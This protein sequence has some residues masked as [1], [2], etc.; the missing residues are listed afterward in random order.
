MASEYAA[1]LL[2]VQDLLSRSEKI[3][4]GNITLDITVLPKSFINSLPK[5]LNEIAR[6]S[7]QNNTSSFS[8]FPRNSTSKSRR[9]TVTLEESQQVGARII[10]SRT[11]MR[12]SPTRIPIPRTKFP[13]FPSPQTKD[14]PIEINSTPRPASQI[15][16]TQPKEP[17]VSK[18]S[19]VYHF[20]NC[21]F[22]SGKNVNNDAKNDFDDTDLGDIVNQTSF[23]ARNEEIDPPRFQIPEI[24]PI[25]QQN[26]T[27]TSNIHFA[28]SVQSKRSL[29][30]DGDEIDNVLEGLSRI[31]ERSFKV[32]A[33]TLSAVSSN[34]IESSLREEY[35]NENVERL[36]SDKSWVRSDTE[37]SKNYGGTEKFTKT[38]EYKIKSPSRRRVKSG[39]SELDI[40]RIT[41]P[42]RISFKDEL[43]FDISKDKL[44]NTESSDSEVEDEVLNNL[45]SGKSITS[46]SS[47]LA[48]K[49]KQK[50]LERAQHEIDQLAKELKQKTEQILKREKSVL[51]ME[52]RIGDEVELLV[53]R[54]VSKRE[55]DFRKE[56][57]SVLDKLNTSLVLAEKENRRLQDS[58][59]ELVAAN[60]LLR[61][62]NKKLEKEVE[63]KKKKLLETNDQ[64]KQYKHRTETL[65]S[66]LTTLKVASST[67]KSIEQ[68]FASKISE[69]KSNYCVKCTHPE[70]GL[71][72]NKACFEPDDEVGDMHIPKPDFVGMSEKEIYEELKKTGHFG[73]FAEGKVEE[74]EN[75][76]VGGTKSTDKVPRD[77]TFDLSP[78]LWT[79][80]EYVV[81]A[82]SVNMA[83]NQ[84]KLLRAIFTVFN[85]VQRLALSNQRTFLGIVIHVAKTENLDDVEC[86]QIA[87]SAFAVFEGLQNSQ[88]PVADEK[89][90]VLLELI[91]LICLRGQGSGKLDLEGVVSDLLNKVAS[92]EI[93]IFMLEHDAVVILYPYLKLIGENSM[94]VMVPV[95]CSLILLNFCG[96]GGMRL[97]FMGYY[98]KLKFE[99]L[100]SEW[101]EPFLASCSNL[102]FLNLAEYVLSTISIRIQNPVGQSE[103]LNGDYET[104]LENF[105]VILQKMSKSKSNYEMMRNQVGLVAILRGFMSVNVESEFVEL[106]I[107][108]ILKNLE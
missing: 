22:H 79:L 78:H 97:I 24:S 86:F 80:M 8:D 69:R 89:I 6:T 99:T 59:T 103:D 10:P 65:R 94:D 51:E 98:Q 5:E 25:P 30:L 55:G 28:S 26:F 32:N 19:K 90:M 36:F 85:A 34:I 101:Y 43:T 47:A 16:Q 92:N 93:K 42:S 21:H 11:A 48:L 66:N 61:S 4:D 105:C 29:K 102:E 76:S 46:R 81:D 100:Y 63:T 77:Q 74:T 60:R 88:I 104:M 1:S 13:S 96:D 87:E 15:P 84:N 56:A 107:R 44:T 71:D 31:S 40:S 3:V 57:D 12:I 75:G 83:K 41:Q 95:L 91:I 108:S 70:H 45:V 9:R 62:K 52:Q 53:L 64:L 54:E 82:Q 14:L 23:P 50:I 17:T 33:K 58:V 35:G 18:P 106:N 68:I 20:T 37:Q 67:A 72:K 73:G 7:R 38:S 39:N 2:S 27:N 49:Q